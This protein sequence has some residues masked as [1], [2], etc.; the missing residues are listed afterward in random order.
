MEIFKYIEYFESHAV[1][2]EARRTEIIYNIHLTL[3]S[4]VYTNIH[5]NEC[6]QFWI[7]RA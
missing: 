4:R 2:R 3:N 6:R 7:S 5:D 1:Y